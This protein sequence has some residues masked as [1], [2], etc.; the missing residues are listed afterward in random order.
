MSGSRD[1]PASVFEAKTHPNPL[2]LSFF[3]YSTDLAGGKLLKF[4]LES[5][6]PN[7]ETST[8]KFAL[9]LVEALRTMRNI[10]EQGA[11]TEEPVKGKL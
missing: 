1:E 4:G 8:T 7:P 5:K 11:P 9:A 6:H 10:C 3:P 2:F